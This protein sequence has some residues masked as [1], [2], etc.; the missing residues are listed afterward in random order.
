MKTIALLCLLS[1]GPAPTPCPTPPV[2]KPPGYQEVCYQEEIGSWHCVD[3]V[4][5]EC[6]EV[7]AEP[8][9]SRWLPNGGCP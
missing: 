3:G 7:S 1:C 8:P 4:K 2:H 6:V 9:T 5:F